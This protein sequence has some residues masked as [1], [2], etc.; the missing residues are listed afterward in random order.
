MIPVYS[1]LEEFDVPGKFV[2]ILNDSHGFINDTFVVTFREQLRDTRYVL[3]RVNNYVFR[4][5]ED[6]MGN[7][8]VITDHLKVKVGGEGEDGEKVGGEERGLKFASIIRTREGRDFYRDDEGNVWRLMTYIEHAKAYETVQGV[9]HAEECGRVLGRF[10]DLVSDIDLTKIRATIAGY[11]VPSEYLR[12]YDEMPKEGAPR[13]MFD[14]VEKHRQEALEL[15]EAERAG[16]L[17]RRLI[18]GD[19]RIN[20][21]MID[22]RTGK[23]VAMI[24]LDTASAGLVQM[25]VGDAVRSICNPAGEDVQFLRDVTFRRDIYQ[26][27]MKGFYAEANHFLTDADREYMNRAIRLLPF[28]LGLRFFTDHLRGDRYFKVAHRG[29]NLRRAMGQFKLYELIEV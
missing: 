9:W 24:D 20:N 6:V 10:L 17:R 8:R 12:Q 22:E 2:D 13:E 7:L 26:A 23:G 16:I 1:I 18:H 15:E 21:I 27:F 25:D 11:H 14:F 28:E 5:P 3:Q 19:P 4:Y 29:Q